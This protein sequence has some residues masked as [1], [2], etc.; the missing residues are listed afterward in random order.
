MGTI[1]EW[2][3][4]IYCVLKEAFGETCTV[5]DETMQMEPPC[6]AVLLSQASQKPGPNGRGQRA[7]VFEVRGRFTS[8]AQMREA[9]DTLFASIG[10][11]T[12][13]DGTCLRGCGMRCEAA[14]G[15]LHFFVRYEG[16]VSAVREIFVMEDLKSVQTLD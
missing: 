3:T 6:L 4:A 10:L 13:P 9:A 14:Y 11:L 8:A 1:N 2:T 16:L 7:V 15:L 12:L 5:G